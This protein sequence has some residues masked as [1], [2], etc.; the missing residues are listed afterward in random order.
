MSNYPDGYQEETEEEFLAAEDV[1]TELE[2]CRQAYSDMLTEQE[3]ERKARI[4]RILEEWAVLR[5]VIRNVFPEGLRA[6]VEFKAVDERYN[7]D[8]PGHMNVEI[9]GASLVVTY[10][11]SDNRYVPM[12][13]LVGDK[14]Y[15]I[16]NIKT[17]IGDALNLSEL[18]R[19][20]DG[21]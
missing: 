17:A 14:T 10:M 18:L 5:R 1:A 13:V 8:C 9:A 21:V 15:P 7:P 11:R 6:F 3:E 20:M 19:K 4:R 16:K 2:R 12:R